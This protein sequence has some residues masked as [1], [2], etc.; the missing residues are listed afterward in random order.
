[1]IIARGKSCEDLGEGVDHG[2]IIL[3]GHAAHEDGIEIIY[4][5]NK[6]ILHRLEGADGEG[7]GQIGVHGARGDVGKGRKAENI[8]GGANFF[9]GVQVVNL[10]SCI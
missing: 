5:R 6:N 3:G 2:T 7:T 4:I 8:V 10:E 9:G 1:M